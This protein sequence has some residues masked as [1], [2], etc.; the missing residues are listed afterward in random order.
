M[1]KP[2]TAYLVCIYGPNGGLRKRR[3]ALN[4]SDAIDFVEYEAH[5]LGATVT[6]DDNGCS[7]KI[8]RTSTYFGSYDIANIG[9][10]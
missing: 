7:G 10:I 3:I 8:A 4:W 2:T 6:E 5:K 1:P 9:V